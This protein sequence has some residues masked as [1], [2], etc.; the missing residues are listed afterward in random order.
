MWH[1]TTDYLD[2]FDITIVV[3]MSYLC[4]TPMYTLVLCQWH[5]II[6]ISVEYLFLS[7]CQQHVCCIVR[8]WALSS[9]NKTLKLRVLPRRQQ[10]LHVIIRFLAFS[11]TQKAGYCNIFLLA[12]V[13]HVELQ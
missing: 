9:F 2:F 11:I 7:V 12:T 13:S 8:T 10:V 6:L 1:L 3:S 4:S 5:V